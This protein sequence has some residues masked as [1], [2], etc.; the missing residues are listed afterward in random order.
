V[1]ICKRHNINYWLTSGTLLG[2]KRHGGFIPWDDDLD[3]VVLQ[4]D[5]KKLLLILKKELPDNLRLQTR[6]TDKNYSLYYAKIRDTNSRYYEEAA[7]C[8]NYNYNG[9]FIDI[10][11]LETVPSSAFKKVID[12]F[13]FSEINLRR[14]KSLYQKIKYT[15]MFSMTPLANVAIWLMRRISYTKNKDKVFTYAY[16]NPMAGLFDLKSFMPP[17]EVMFEGKTYQAPNNVD[18]FLT[19]KYGSDFMIIP[20]SANR[21][22]HASNIEFM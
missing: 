9:L 13:L 8:F 10:F 6:E 17:G 5:F 11:P 4:K 16:G 15:A 3:I 19:D 7:A 21:R 22:T 14:S 20:Q 2:A 1:Q 12:K 18:Q